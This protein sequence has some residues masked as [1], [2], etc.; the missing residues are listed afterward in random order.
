M[1]NENEVDQNQE[2]EIKV[3]DVENESYQEHTIIDQIQPQKEVEKVEDVPSRTELDHLRILW[4]KNRELFKDLKILKL[5]KIDELTRDQY[6]ECLLYVNTSLYAKNNSKITWGIF[7]GIN[8]FISKIFN[9]PKKEFDADIELYNCI[10]NSPISNLITKIPYVLQA[11]LRY[12][13]KVVEMKTKHQKEEKENND[14]NQ[15]EPNE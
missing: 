2:H 4:I 5:T 1:E 6:N 11:P 7:K 9:I 3:L 12:V 13:F 14:N 8:L 15:E 10:N